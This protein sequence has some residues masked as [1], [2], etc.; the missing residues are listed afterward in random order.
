MSDDRDHAR[1]ETSAHEAQEGADS[2]GRNLTLAT[3]TSA[4]QWR[5]RKGPQLELI[6]DQ[7]CLVSD[8]LSAILST[9]TRFD[10][11]FQWILS[12]PGKRVRAGMVLACAQLK[13]SD[14]RVS[15]DDAVD[16]ACAIEMFHESSL[17]HD[18]IC[19][20]SVLRRDAESVPSAFGI[21]TAA[22]A[23]FHLAGTA[24]Q[25]LAQVQARN[26]KTF[27]TL[28]DAHGVTY[29][30][31]ISDL[32]FGQIVET[33]PP[34]FNDAALRRHY[35]LVAGAKTGTLFR[36]ACSYGGTAGA[37]DHD[38]LRVLMVYANQLALAFQIMDDVR[39]VEGAPNLGKDACGDLD[40]RIPTWPVIEW[41]AMRR[42]RAREIWLSPTVSSQVIQAELLSTG[43]SEAA[44]AAAIAAAKRASEAIDTFPLSA[45]R[46]HL[47]ELS[48]RVVTR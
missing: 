5:K 8:R 43:A 40:R 9:G 22:L 28:G 4:I 6:S 2:A 37:L 15:L 31:Q 20:G 1:G 29:L 19:D 42:P 46:E 12:T 48:T 10:D 14:D 24:L 7:M 17:I 36:L 13:P 47:R 27:A 41:L 23:G 33:L 38:Q 34:A 45:A 21:R 32:S 39:D 25:T 44:H 35:E 3:N 11:I 26:P 16:M 18:D 30:D